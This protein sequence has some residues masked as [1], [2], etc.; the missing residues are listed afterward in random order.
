MVWGQNHL[1]SELNNF[2]GWFERQTERTFCSTIIKSLMLKREPYPAI[3]NK[4]VCFLGAEAEVNPPPAF[5]TWLMRPHLFPVPQR[6]NKHRK[7][8]MT[9]G[10]RDCRR[11]F[12][13]S[14]ALCHY[15]IQYTMVYITPRWAD[16]LCSI[17]PQSE[18]CRC[19]KGGRWKHLAESFPKKYRSVLA[20]A[21]SWLSGNR[22]WETA[23]GVSYTHRCIR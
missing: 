14:A 11:G 7:K 21:P 19:Q 18:Q 10:K 23:P 3:S 6:R 12:R 5:V 4:M 15:R 2:A 22:A 13:F 9:R 20:L 17:P 1:K 16:F 8:K